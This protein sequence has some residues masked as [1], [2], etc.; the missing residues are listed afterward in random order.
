ML[1]IFLDTET[2]GLDFSIHNILEIAFV[3]MDLRT[4]TVLESFERI[5]QVTEDEWALSNLYS[6]SFNGISKEMMLSGSSKEIVVKDIK[7]IFHKHKLT[8]GKSVFICQNPSFDRLF[9]SK[10]IPVDY[11]EKHQFPYHWLDLA[12][13][14]FAKS[15]LQ[16]IPIDEIHLSKDQIADKYH[17]AK[18]SKPHRAINGVLHLIECYKSVVK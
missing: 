2:N 1:G 10:L 7:K 4:N 16:K 3:I 13:M 9:F 11:Q 15:M 14:H 12:S 8:K 5:L 18:E 6:L 17:I